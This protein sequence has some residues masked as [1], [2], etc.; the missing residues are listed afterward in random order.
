MRRDE[1]FVDFGQ[2]SSPGLLRAAYLLTGDRNHAEDRPRRRRWSDL[3][4]PGHGGAPRDSSPTRGEAVQPFTDRWRRRLR[5]SATVTVPDPRPRR[6]W[7]RSWRSQWLIGALASLD[8]G[9][10]G[11]LGVVG[12]WMCHGVPVGTCVLIS[13]ITSIFLMQPWH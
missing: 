6:P 8:R 3:C 7:R 1:D 5:E 9:G 11:W 10:G 4:L 12:W 2:A 13:A